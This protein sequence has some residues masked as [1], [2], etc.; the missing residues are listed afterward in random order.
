MPE[1][2]SRWIIVPGHALHEKGLQRQIGVGTLVSSQERRALLVPLIN[3]GSTARFV[4]PSVYIGFPLFVLPK[5]RSG[6]LSSIAWRARGT[7]VSWANRPVGVR[8]PVPAL[9]RRAP[10]RPDPPVVCPGFGFDRLGK[11]W[12]SDLLQ[13][14]TDMLDGKAYESRL[15]K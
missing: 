14:T 7:F 15:K 11:I 6:Q 1:G 9:P 8:L 4:P 10:P 3:R 13:T 2:V 5:R 12:K